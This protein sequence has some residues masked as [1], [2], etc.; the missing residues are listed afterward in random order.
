MRALQPRFFRL[1][2]AF[3]RGPMLDFT[4]SG[5]VK[6]APLGRIR[7]HEIMIKKAG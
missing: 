3:Q 2:A 4:R 6:N 5:V 1:I 7:T